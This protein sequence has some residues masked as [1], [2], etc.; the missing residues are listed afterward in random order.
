[1]EAAPTCRSGGFRF[2]EAAGYLLVA[3]AV[4][5]G[6]EIVKT[7]LAIRTPPATAI[8]LAPTSPEVLRR[9]A[10][11]ELLAGRVDNARMLASE[12]LIRAPFDARA[13]RVRGLAEAKLGSVA[14]ADEMLTLAGNWSLRDDPAH[15]WL[16]EQRLRGGDYGSAF[17][18]ADTLARRRT[19][20]HPSVFQLFTLAAGSDTRAIPHLA[21]LLAAQPPWRSAYLDYLHEDDSRAPVAGALVVALNPTS[22][23]F[24]TLELKQLYTTWAATGRMEGIK[25]VRRR[26]GRPSLAAT[27]QN[28]D[29][30]LSFEDQMLPF[31]WRLETGPGISSASVEDDLR[32]GNLA[33]RVEYDGFVSGF[34]AEQLLFLAPGDY[35]LTGSR[36]AE[37]SM[38]DLRMTWQIVCV[39]TGSPSAGAGAVIPAAAQDVEWQPFQVRFRVAAENCTAQWLRLQALPGDRRTTIAAWFDDLRIRQVGGASAG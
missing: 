13:M 16:V 11:G 15:A 36:R 5:L 1:M 3:G 22:G 26:T 25:D 20:L 6:W 30:S 29:F 35:V 24:S 37:T 31:G 10:E 33:F 19:D 39:E 18:H 28:G 38:I 2:V 14:R 32:P 27:L 23:R 7:P 8:R 34:F 17:A 9:A 4:W 21:R 12:A